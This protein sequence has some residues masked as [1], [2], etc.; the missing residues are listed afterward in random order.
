MDVDFVEA[1]FPTKISQFLFERE[2]TNKNPR[3][4]N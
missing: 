3:P 1:H 4:K 2:M